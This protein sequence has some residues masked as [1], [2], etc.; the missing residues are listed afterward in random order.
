VALDDIEGVP[1]RPQWLEP[2]EAVALGRGGHF[3]AEGVLHDASGN[4]RCTGVVRSTGQQ[5]K[6]FSVD[7]E[8]F[9]KFHGGVSC[10]KIAAK[11]RIY[12]EVIEDPTMKNVYESTQA[13]GEV[14]SVKE[15]LGLLRALLAKYVED[16]HVNE[17]GDLKNISAVIGEIR[18]L[19]GDCTKIEVRLGQL[20]EVGSIVHVV[21]QLAAII[22]KYIKDADTLESI[23]HEFDAVIWPAPLA[24][25]PQPRRTVSSTQVQEGSGKVLPGSVGN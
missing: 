19:V 24:S 13:E 23:A 25:T 9:C 16:F 1:K 12:S 2:V 5:C 20:I 3:D 15:E 4:T 7:G 21:K 14:N 18:Q 8:L 6:N 10:R 11:E 17:T 22:G